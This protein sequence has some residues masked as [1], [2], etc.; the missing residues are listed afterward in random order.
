MNAKTTMYHKMKLLL[1]MRA[2][3]GTVYLK[4]ILHVISIVREIFILN[5]EEHGTEIIVPKELSQDILP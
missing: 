2:L 5:F 4:V 1:S 3:R